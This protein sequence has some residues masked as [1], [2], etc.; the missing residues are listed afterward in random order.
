V[1]VVVLG[2]LGP[3]E[4]Q[5]L[6]VKHACTAGRRAQVTAAPSAAAA[7]RCRNAALGRAAEEPGRAAG[8]AMQHGCPPPCPFS[9]QAAG[10]RHWPGYQSFH[11]ARGRPPHALQHGLP[12]SG[13]AHGCCMQRP[14]LA[15]APIAAAAA[16]RPVMQSLS[17]AL[18]R[19]AACGAHT[20]TAAARS[21]Y[22]SVLTVSMAEW[23]SMHVS[24]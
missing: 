13:P 19:C 15:A 7:Q 18:Y 17:A 14:A 8:R 2:E 10:H 23:S 24:L 1:L 20:R 21:P 11:G 12:S 3:D 4:R 5:R 9:P 22:L 6:A 16:A